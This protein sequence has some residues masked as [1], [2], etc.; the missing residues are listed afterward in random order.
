MGDERGARGA[1]PAGSGPRE[2]RRSDPRS[3]RPRL[4]DVG[5]DAPDGLTTN[6]VFDRGGVE[7]A[8]RDASAERGVDE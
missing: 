2:G 7:T 8:G 6:D 1:R 4:R 5:H 3:D